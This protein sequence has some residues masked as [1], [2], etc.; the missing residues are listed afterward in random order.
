MIRGR[1]LRLGAALFVFGLALGLRLTGLGW[2]EGSLGHPDERFLTLVASRIDYPG[3][4]GEYLDTAASPANP[5]NRGHTFFVYG[6]LPI[7][8]TRMIAD[9][10]GE[11]GFW[12]L[13]LVGRGLSALLDALVV[14]MSFALARRL[15]S[16]EAGLVAASLVATAVIHVQHAHF[17]VVDPWLTAAATAA[18]LALT[19][20][21]AG[22]RSAAPV[23]GLAVGLAVA[24]KLSGAVLIAP[25][26]GAFLVAWLDRD[27]RLAVVVDAL[28]FAVVAAVVVRITHPYAF[29]AG[30]LATPD[31]Q[32]VSSLERLRASATSF[33]YPPAIQW[34]GIPRTHGIVQVALWGTGLL[35]AI[36]GLAGVAL[37]VV[38]VWKG[39][40]STAFPA[41]VWVLV[42]VIATALQPVQPL[43]YLL[44]LCPALLVFAGIALVE[45]G[46]TVERRATGRRWLAWLPLAATVLVSLVWSL[47]FVRIYQT[48]H[49][50]AEATRWILAHAAAGETIAVETWDEP[51]PGLVAGREPSIAPSI[52]LPVFAANG[53]ATRGQMIARLDRSDW[54]VIASQRGWGAIPRVPARFPE[55]LRY[56]RA[57]LSGELGFEPVRV[58]RDLPG[59]GLW[60]VDTLAA[61]ESFSV[62]DHPTVIVFRKGRRWNPGRA[63]AIMS[64]LDDQR[65]LPD[66]RELAALV[67]RL[68][69][70]HRAGSDG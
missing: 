62:Y 17:F 6:T 56:Y 63:A 54:L 53:P 23:A 13:Y 50:R 14:V 1:G 4:I 26:A 58:F 61:D 35:P 32:L 65:P 55:T 3:S 28:L 37:G 12:H 34:Y 51:I 19:A 69:D 38:R 2:D 24:C 31:P 9:A 39:R 15:H 41:L 43:R 64:G 46:R 42:G 8:V 16:E 66:R 67:R 30:S 29:A 11:G 27:R 10:L 59:V 68:D 45:L 60:E 47:A 7:L 25:A 52:Q 33:D 20:V 22:G 48:P 21:A 70:L 49:V 5:V 36:A 18:V 44:P 57:L 40:W